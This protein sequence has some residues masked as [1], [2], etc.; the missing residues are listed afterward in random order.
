MC[1]VFEDG[2]YLVEVGFDRYGHVC[3]EVVVELQVCEFELFV[4]V[5]VWGVVCAVV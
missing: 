1:F 2:W 3:F 4:L 5:P